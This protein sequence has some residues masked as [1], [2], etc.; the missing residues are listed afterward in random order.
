MLALQSM[1]KLPTRQPQCLTVST[2][3]LPFTD[4]TAVQSEQEMPQYAALSAVPQ[5][6]PSQQLP[7]VHGPGLAAGEQL[8]GQ[9]SPVPQR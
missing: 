4:E 2:H 1:A 7:L 3:L 9:A 8:V 5:L 6:V